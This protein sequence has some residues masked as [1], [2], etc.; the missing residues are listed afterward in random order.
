MPDPTRRLL[1]SLPSALEPLAAWNGSSPL[2]RGL[3]DRQG[4]VAEHGGIIP[5]RAGFTRAFCFSMFFT[6]DHPR[7]RGVYETERQ[8]RGHTFG[9]SPLA[10]GLLLVCGHGFAASGIIP[11]R[12]GFTLVIGRPAFAGPDHP[13]SRGV[14]ATVCTPLDSS[15]GP[16][17]LARGLHHINNGKYGVDRII[18]ARAGFT[19]LSGTTW[20]RRL[21]HPRSRG[22]YKKQHF[23]LHL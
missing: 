17:P 16:S 8:A 15:W 5:A 7:S 3:H 9:S 2:A 20:R 10:R 22:V 11:A 18:P 21:D 1:P 19:L 6:E 23:R 4:Q 12:A 13:R 14:Y